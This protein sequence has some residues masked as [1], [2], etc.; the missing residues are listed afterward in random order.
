MILDSVMA[1]PS[2]EICTRLKNN[3]QIH[4]DPVLM[5]IWSYVPDMLCSYVLAMVVHTFQVI[6]CNTA[7]Y[8]NIIKPLYHTTTVIQ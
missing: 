6:P 3:I 7:L 8:N 5:K 1:A 4:S 2:G